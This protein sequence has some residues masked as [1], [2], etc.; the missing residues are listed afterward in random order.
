M[1]NTPE[2]IGDPMIRIWWVG[3]LL[4]ELPALLVFGY[5]VSFTSD[6]PNKIILIASKPWYLHYINR[7]LIFPFRLKTKGKK[8]PIVIIASAILFNFM[9]GFINGYW[10]AKFAPESDNILI[11]IGIVIGLLIFLI[12]LIINQ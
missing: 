10:L 6:W 7:S 2:V 11:D 4:M 8:I 3:W 1:A 12:D 9:N 5:F